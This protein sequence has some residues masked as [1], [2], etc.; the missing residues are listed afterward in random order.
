MAGV[1]LVVT[2]PWAPEIEVV[3]PGSGGRRI[4]HDGLLGNYY[5]AP[6]GDRRPAVLV[7]G[8]SEGGIGRGVD[9]QARTLRDEG[10]STLVL[11]YWGAEG[12]S[13]RMEHL[14]LETFDTAL[15]WLG[16]QPE[17]DPDRLA[18]A[19]GSKGAEAALLVAT[20][21]GDV[22][23]VVAAMP[24]SVVWPGIDLAE[25]WRMAGIGSTWSAQGHPLP[26]L[27][28]GSA[29]FGQETVAMYASGLDAVGEHPDAVIPV[30]RAG[31]PV[32]L[33]AGEDDTLW[34]S[35][36]MARDVERR[37][38]ESGGP[39]VTVLAYPDAGH[40]AQGPPPE[41]GTDP[42]VLTSLGGTAEGNRAA[43]AA[44]WPATVAFLREHL[45]G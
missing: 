42:D 3:D 1:V 23:A 6:G 36:R 5:P 7:L 24:S 11:S 43:T 39:P 30:E 10:F 8:G 9:R 20:R 22:R 18:V 34:P 13:P 26:A 21:R 33:V 38:R 35:A 2:K 27:P 4:T 12:Q 29:G 17:A 44:A 41:E 40:M 15:A 19:G 45:G 28:Y 37:A 16:R 31:A 25:P 32:L 14:P